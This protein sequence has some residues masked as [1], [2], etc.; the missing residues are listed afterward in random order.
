M[1]TNYRRY[2]APSGRMHGMKVSRFV[3]LLCLS[4]VLHVSLLLAT[5]FSHLLR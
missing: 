2:V 5:M 4:A 1:S 3:D